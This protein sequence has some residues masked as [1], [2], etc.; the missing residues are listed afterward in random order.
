VNYTVLI[1]KEKFNIIDEF[2]YP[3]FKFGVD[4]ITVL[5][6]DTK[7]PQGLQNGKNFLTGVIPATGVSQRVNRMLAIRTEGRHTV[8]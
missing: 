3:G 7:T 4:I 5:L 8:R 2:E 1:R 6:H